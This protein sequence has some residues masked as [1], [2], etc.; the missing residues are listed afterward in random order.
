MTKI[1]CGIR[2]TLTH[3]IRDLTATRE[4]GFTKICARDAGLGK[5]KGSQANNGSSG[6]GILVKRS[7]NAGSGPPLSN[8][9]YFCEN[10]QSEFDFYLLTCW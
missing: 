7:K 4:S 1:Q 2:K 5:E 9:K 6:R 8:S 10:C 3:G